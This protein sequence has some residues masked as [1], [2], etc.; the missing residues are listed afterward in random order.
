[1][2]IPRE[3]RLALACGRSLSTSN[4]FVLSGRQDVFHSCDNDIGLLDLDV[5]AA[6]LGNQP[7]APTRR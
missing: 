5:V 6:A 2:P 7:S 4:L 1:L 3:L